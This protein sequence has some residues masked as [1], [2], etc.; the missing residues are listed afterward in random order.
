M[1]SVLLERQQRKLPGG[2]H[3]PPFFCLIQNK[4]HLHSGDLTI[5]SC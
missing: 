4:I 2:V 3:S 5:R 1:I